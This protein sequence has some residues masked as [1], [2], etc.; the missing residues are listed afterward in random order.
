M[1]AWLTSGSLKLATTGKDVKVDFY[2]A[3]KGAPRP[4]WGCRLPTTVAD[5]PVLHGQGQSKQL[6]EDNRQVLHL[7]RFGL[8]IAGV[9]QLLLLTAQT[10]HTSTVH[11]DHHVQYSPVRI[12]PRRAFAPC[13][14][15]T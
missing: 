13:K 8:D 12:V 1:A 11:H 14:Q 5:M 2:L 9:V 10:L 7:P 6:A 15:A 3:A 4:D